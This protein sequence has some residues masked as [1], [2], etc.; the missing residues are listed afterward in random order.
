MPSNLPAELVPKDVRRKAV[1][2]VI[3]E[4]FG[5]DLFRYPES[6]IDLVLSL[7]PERSP[8]GAALDLGRVVAACSVGETMFLRHPEHFSAL[9]HVALSLPSLG[10][11]PIHVWS[12]GCATGEEAYS[13]A[14]VLHGLVPVRV[15][16][17]DLNRRSIERASEGIYR[18][19]STR[20]VDAAQVEDWLDIDGMD[21]LVRPHVQELVEFR[22]HNLVDGGFPRDLDVI[23]CRNVLLYFDAT[24]ARIVLRAFQD[25]LAPGGVLFLGYCDPEP[26]DAG[27]W[28]PEWVNNTRFFRK[29]PAAEPRSTVAARAPS[30]APIPRAAEARP[31]EAERI[32]PRFLDL[33]STARGL[34]A[35]AAFVEALRLL[36]TLCREYPLEVSP[37]VLSAMIAEEAG[38]PDAA[39]AAAR[40]ALFLVPDEPIAHY[41]VGACLLRV[42][43]LYRAQFHFRSARERLA[44]MGP[45]AELRCAEGLTR[46]QLGRLIDA[47]LVG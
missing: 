24:A 13:I 5:I 28:L 29:P 46:N 33:L 22:V 12:A 21:V 8:S 35:Q 2:A 39:L 14:A 15:L 4:R 16:G 42:G 19:W 38:L 27:G 17:T 3:R 32:A 37:C 9:R 10:K 7:V 18:P 41:L 1:A 36:E 26:E 11:R 34:A 47:R 43:E 20:G 6:T 40:R 23:F 44:R 45:H 31:P 25:S 30:R